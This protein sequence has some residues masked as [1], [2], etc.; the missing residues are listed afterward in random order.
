MLGLGMLDDH[1]P[2]AGVLRRF[3]RVSVID[4]GDVDFM[5]VALW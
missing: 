5:T 3:V 4:K 1:Q 2:H